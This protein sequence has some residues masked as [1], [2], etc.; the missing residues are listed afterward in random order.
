MRLVEKVFKKD[1]FEKEVMKIIN[2]ICKNAP[3]TIAAAKMSIDADD[4]NEAEYK[5]CLQAEKD[6]F[7]SKDYKEG[8][9]AFAEKRKPNF[10]G[11]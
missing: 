2:K 4:T 1:V 10:E 3:L 9:L 11:R 8:R 5:K 6:C 7:E